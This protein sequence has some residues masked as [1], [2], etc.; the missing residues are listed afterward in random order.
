MLDPELQYDSAQ[1]AN[2]KDS[3]MWQVFLKYLTN[4][5]DGALSQ[6]MNPAINDQGTHHFR[7]VYTACVDMSRIPDQVINHE[8]ESR[9]NA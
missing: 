7:G 4:L 6:V 3:P 1:M 2:L 5:K 9:V 8:K